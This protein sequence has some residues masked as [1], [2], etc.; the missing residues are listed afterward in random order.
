MTPD[1]LFDCREQFIVMGAKGLT[2]ECLSPGLGVPI[3]LEELTGRGEES[4][5][6]FVKRC[7]IGST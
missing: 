1:H 3:T 2:V 7:R 5:Q 4:V 6:L